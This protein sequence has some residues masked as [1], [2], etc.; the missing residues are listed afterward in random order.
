MVKKVKTGEPL[1]AEQEQE[2]ARRL[3]QPTHYFNE[4]N[5]RRA[6][7]RPGGNLIDFVKA[8]LGTSKLKSR[9]EETTENFQAWLVTKNFA[10]EQA[11]YL[12]LLKNRGIARGKVE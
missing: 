6:Y 5:L 1:T 3:N 10:P 9:A 7:R 11:S 2:L 12:T 4:D 8:A